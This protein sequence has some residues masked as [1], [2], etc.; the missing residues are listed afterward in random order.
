MKKLIFTTFVS[1]LF[2][3]STIFYVAPIISSLSSSAQAEVNVTSLWPSKWSK[4][5][6]IYLRGSNLQ[7]YQQETAT[8]CWAA[9]LRTAHLKLNGEALSECQ[10]SEIVYD[11]NLCDAKG[12]WDSMKSYHEGTK[13]GPFNLAIR[14]L[15]MKGDYKAVNHK[16]SDY[17]WVSTIIDQIAQ[18]KPVI[19][20][21]DVLST[22]TQTHVMIVTGAKIKKNKISFEVFEPTT[23]SF[24]EFNPLKKND[25]FFGVEL[26]GFF[27]L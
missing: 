4:F 5:N 2:Q 22:Q 27:L 8:T 12:S 17:K 15:G 19:L 24:F 10:I 7:Y 18:N 26:A 21:G 14:K 6:A 23:N 20:L 1:S 3:L 11:K 25:F 16:S 13:S 9:V